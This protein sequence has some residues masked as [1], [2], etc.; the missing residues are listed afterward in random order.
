[1][2]ELVKGNLEG[3]PAVVAV[4]D[5]SVRGRWAPIRF[6][7]KNQ[8]SPAW[9]PEP[10]EVARATLALHLQLRDHGQPLIDQHLMAPG[11]DADLGCLKRKRGARH[12]SLAAA[13]LLIPAQ[14]GRPSALPKTRAQ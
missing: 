4:E 2:I 9:A 5:A 12:R 11:V 14:G 13:L 1:M 6:A 10:A 7:A 3:Y 8:V